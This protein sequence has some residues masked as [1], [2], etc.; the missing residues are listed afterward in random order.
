MASPWHDLGGIGKNVV[1]ETT[2]ISLLSDRSFS[3]TVRKVAGTR[4]RRRRPSRSELAEGGIEPDGWTWTEGS[5]IFVEA[6]LGDPDRFW[7]VMALFTV[8]DG[9]A[10]MVE[11]R[12]LPGEADRF[13]NE[14]SYLYDEDGTPYPNPRVADIPE[15]G[16]WSRSRAALA[17]LPA[18]LTARLVQRIRFGELNELMRRELESH[19]SRERPRASRFG[20]DLEQ[21]TRRPGRKGRPDLDFARIAARYA[22]KVR[23]GSSR[24][25]VELAEELGLT[26]QQVRDRIHE[27]RVRDLLTDVRQGAVGGDLTTE[28]KQLLRNSRRPGRKAQ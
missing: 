27:A 10:V 5:W 22:D 9:Q 6:E 23:K 11:L 1:K 8:H 15:I 16:E 4:Q 7:V 12:V 21:A 14:E 24:P 3:G 2:V 25:N 20:F 18:G 28:A 19:R 26:P 13:T 17:D